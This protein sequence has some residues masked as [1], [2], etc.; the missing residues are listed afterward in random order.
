MTI[1]QARAAG[2]KGAVGAAVINLFTFIF[3]NI[4]PDVLTT[5]GQSITPG[6]ALLAWFV[7][8]LMGSM[9]MYISGG[10][11]DIYRVWRPF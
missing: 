10:K 4:D 8:V 1:Q 9:V 6:P 5:T 11:L 2:L 3:R 7:G